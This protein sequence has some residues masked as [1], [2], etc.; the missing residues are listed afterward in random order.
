[1]GIKLLFLYF[2]LGG[3]LVALITYLGSQGKGLLAVFIAFFP[4]M[5]LVTFSTIYLN[6]GTTAATTFA[7]SL[8]VMTPAWL[9]YVATVMVLL[10]RIGLVRSLLLGILSYLVASLLTMRLASG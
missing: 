5:S 10:P 2:I 3:M 9:A 7:R 6:G 4:S 8:I 1:M